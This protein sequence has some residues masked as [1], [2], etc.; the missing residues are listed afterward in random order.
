MNGKTS[1]LTP[2]ITAAR[3]SSWAEIVARAAVILL[4]FALLLAIILLRFSPALIGREEV[5][6]HARMP[7]QGGWSQNDISVQAGQPL[8]MSLV[9]DDV[10]HSFKIGQDD[11]PAI[12]LLPGKPVETTLTFEQ[13]GKYTFYC[14][15]WCGPNHWRMRGVIDVL[16][17][18]GDSKPDSKAPTP[19]YVQLG[20]DIDSPHPAQTVPQ[21]TPSAQQGAELHEPISPKY[22]SQVYLRSHSPAQVWDDLRLDPAIQ[23][24][25]EQQVWDLVAY[26]WASNTSA[27]KLALGKNLYAENCAACH[28]EQGA[29]DGVFAVQPPGNDET[30]HEQ[31]GIDGHS[32][33]APTDFSAAETMLGASPAVLQGKIVRGGMGSGMPYWG[34]VFTEE[35]IWALV[36]YL[37]T[38]QFDAEVEP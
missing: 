11:R 25:S 12:D 2:Q 20:I 31:T 27:Q 33:V 38:F 16:P 9:S 21:R 15:R 28:G 8:H 10:L 6:V 35:Q 23:V 26:L 5:I 19:L 18:S 32:L 7:E 1:S 24:L 17:A 13:P 34:P 30:I 3:Q 37:W 36:D 4:L 22:T 29:G 14:T